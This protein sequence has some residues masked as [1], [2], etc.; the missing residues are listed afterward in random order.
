MQQRRFR[1]ESFKRDAVRRLM[2]RGTET[3]A[4]TAKALGREPEHASSPARTLGARA[5]GQYA[6]KSR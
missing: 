2:A 3:V 4:E 6:D 5:S 1:P